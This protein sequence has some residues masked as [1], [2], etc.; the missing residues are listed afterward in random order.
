MKKIVMN[1]EQRLQRINNNLNFY[2][3]KNN[4][5]INELRSLI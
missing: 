1:I 2:T 5:G 3:D 4:S